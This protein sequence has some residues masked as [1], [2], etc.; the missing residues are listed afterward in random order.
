MT[1]EP[2]PA[3]DRFAHFD[4]SLEET[5]A[6]PPA[7]EARPWLAQQRFVHGMLRALNT[8]DASA[9]EARVQSVMARLP[10]RGR[11]RRQVAAA[12]AAL[13]VL[14]CA[15]VWVVAELGRLPRAEAMVA[16]AL[17]ALRLPVDRAF[18]LR[19]AIEQNGKHSERVMQVVMRPGRR[20]LVSGEASWGK[21]EAGCDGEEIWFRQAQGPFKTS[22]P[23]AEAHRLTDR[24][25]DV[26]DLGYL[27]LESLIRRLPEATELRCVGREAGG[28][29]VEAIGTVQLRQLELRSV[30]MLVDDRTGLLR[31]VEAVAAGTRR[32]TAV[33]VHL[34]YR[35]VGDR[36]LG[37][38]AY[39]RPW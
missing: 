15:I 30:R 5:D 13:L 19:I 20:F 16:Q 18:E 22:L 26:L 28:I 31:D 14:G 17:A 29:R 9:H 23:L 33:D 34:H 2:E 6:A 36:D 35:H 27:D 25:A 39:R 32:G 7:P 3:D 24:L 8:A 11:R 38:G 4:D 10:E 1:R 37:E 21:F 12:A